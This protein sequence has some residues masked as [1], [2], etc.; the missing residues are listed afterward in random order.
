MSNDEEHAPSAAASE[1]EDDEA[2]AAQVSP[3]VFVS[4]RFFL[5]FSL[6]L[7]VCSCTGTVENKLNSCGVLT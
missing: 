2:E 1:N 4:A 7:V 6:L 3:F 5:V